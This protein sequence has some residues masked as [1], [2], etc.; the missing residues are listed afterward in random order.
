MENDEKY[1]QQVANELRTTGP[2][3]ALWLKAFASANADKEKAKA[4]YIKW[5][6]EQLVAA[7]VQ[8]RRDQIIAAELQKH[9]P[10]TSYTIECPKCHSVETILAA[11]VKNPSSYRS[12]KITYNSFLGRIKFN[13]NQ[14]GK[15]FKKYTQLLD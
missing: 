13:C 4:L 5:R 1:Y 9:K 7:D 8:K 3:E 14:C 10:K 6:V 12:F 11:F 15:I 2:I